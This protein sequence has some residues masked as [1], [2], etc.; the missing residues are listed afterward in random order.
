MHIVALGKFII[1]K[2]FIIEEEIEMMK[3]K[4]WLIR[5]LPLILLFVLIIS[6]L[7]YYRMQTLKLVSLTILD[8]E[9]TAEGEYIVQE[10]SEI[11]III[12]TD[13]GRTNLVIREFF[14]NGIYYRPGAKINEENLTTYYDEDNEGPFILAKYTIAQNQETITL[15]QVIV[16]SSRGFAIGNVFEDMGKATLKIIIQ[17]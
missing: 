12:R 6:M 9:I 14:L 2:V 7:F 16:G 17:E 5:N 15:S 3:S 10:G 1:E 4:N 11:S 13:A 8:A